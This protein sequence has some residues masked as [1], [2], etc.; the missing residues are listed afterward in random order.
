[1]SPYVFLLG[2]KGARRLGVFTSLV[3]VLSFPFVGFSGSS[4]AELAANSVYE[5]CEDDVPGESLRGREPGLLTVPQLKRWLACRGASRRRKEGRAGV[6]SD[7]VY[8]D[9]S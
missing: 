5:L 2:R 6:A 8:R 9:G 1:M 7:G 4:M 3:V